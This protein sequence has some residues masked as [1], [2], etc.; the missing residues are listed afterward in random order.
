MVPKKLTTECVVQPIYLFFFLFFP[1]NLVSGLHLNDSLGKRYISLSHKPFMEI[2]DPVILK[3]VLGAL[4]KKLF[5]YWY[6]DHKLIPIL[7]PHPPSPTS[8]KRG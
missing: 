8:P 4:E 2:S 6:L 5:K 3:T 1:E 7:P